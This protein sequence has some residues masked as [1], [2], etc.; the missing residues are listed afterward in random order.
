MGCKQLGMSDANFWIRNDSPED[1]LCQKWKETVLMQSSVTYASMLA[2]TIINQLIFLVMPI[3]VGW[4]SLPTITAFTNEKM[5]TTFVALLITTGLLVLI[6]NSA[7]LGQ[8]PGLGELLN[9]QYYDISDRQFFVAVGSSLS[10][11]I[12]V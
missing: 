8:I 11:T 9:G 7:L 10:I 5:T 1:E 12:T 6:V 3:F 4:M 2:V